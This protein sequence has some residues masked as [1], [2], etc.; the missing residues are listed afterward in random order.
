MADD[1]QAFGNISDSDTDQE[2]DRILFVNTTRPIRQ[3]A[4]IGTQDQIN[5]YNILE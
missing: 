4:A 1:S 5:R 2:I 3:P